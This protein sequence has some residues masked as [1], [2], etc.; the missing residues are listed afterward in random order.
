MH[1]DGGMVFENPMRG[2]SHGE[3]SGLDGFGQKDDEARWQHAPDSFG[4][5]D[6]ALPRAHETR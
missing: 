5:R 2:S 6:R 4:W 3:S 1:V